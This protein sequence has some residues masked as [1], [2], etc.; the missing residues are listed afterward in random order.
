MTRSAAELNALQSVSAGR[1]EREY[2]AK[3]NVFKSGDTSPRVLWA[4][5]KDGLITDG[6]TLSDGF[7]IRC[8][9]VLTKRGQQVLAEAMER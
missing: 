2:R 9:V 4:L 3:G 6:P 1:V 5:A 8:L 7:V